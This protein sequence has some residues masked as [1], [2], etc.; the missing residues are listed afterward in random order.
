MLLIDV[1]SSIRLE[2]EVYMLI[3]LTIISSF[4]IGR[5]KLQEQI[6]SNLKRVASSLSCEDGFEM[7][8]SYSFHSVLD[9]CCEL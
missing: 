4:S 9:L 2:F 1:F 7:W 6:F 8:T 5:F 3:K